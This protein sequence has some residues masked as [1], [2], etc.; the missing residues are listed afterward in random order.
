M[1]PR[2]FKGE[3]LF[4]HPRIP[5]DIGDFVVASINLPSSPAG[6][7]IRQLTAYNGDKYELSQINPRKTLKVKASDVKLAKI[8]F[9]G[10]L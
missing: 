1:E 7:F 10:R 6:T 5:V 3:I 4:V 9:S 2:Y 8:V